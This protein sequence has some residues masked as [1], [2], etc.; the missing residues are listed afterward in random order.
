L[1][2][3]VTRARNSVIHGTMAVAPADLKRLIADVDK[4]LDALP[5]E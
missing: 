5:I 1:L 4:I 3:D 2:E